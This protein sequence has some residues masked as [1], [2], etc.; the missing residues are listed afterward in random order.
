MLNRNTA[1][2]R[3]EFLRL[4]ACNSRIGP[5]EALFLCLVIYLRGPPPVVQPWGGTLLTALP[6]SLMKMSR[7][8]GLGLV[9]ACEFR[10]EA[11]FYLVYESI[12]GNAIDLR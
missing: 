3:V 7:K 9:P 8:A 4:T 6:H 1:Q 5:C 10:S 2:R 12:D 11:L